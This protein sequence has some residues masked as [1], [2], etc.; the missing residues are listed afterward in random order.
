MSS[1]VS[2]MVLNV[3]RN[4][5][6][7]GTGRR[8]ERRDGDGGGERW[9]WGETDIIIISVTECIVCVSGHDPLTFLSGFFSFLIG[10][11]FYGPNYLK[12]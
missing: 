3:H 12:C 1:A 2:N 4:H 6:L 7:L 8:G 5:S 11:E 10:W 9:R